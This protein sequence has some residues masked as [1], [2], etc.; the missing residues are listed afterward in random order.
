MQYTIDQRVK[1]DLAPELAD[2]YI[3]P[4]NVEM[5]VISPRLDRTVP[6][7]CRSEQAPS[8][9]G[10][11]ASGEKKDPQVDPDASTTGLPEDNTPPDAKAKTSEVNIPQEDKGTPVDPKAKTS[12]A[13][14]PPEEQNKTSDGLVDVPDLGD[15]D[16]ESPTPGEIR[17]S[18]AAVRARMRRVME[19]SK[20]TG[21]RK[22]SD[23][24]VK[25]WQTKKGKDKLGAI[26]Q[27]C[28]Y[29]TDW[30]FPDRVV[31]CVC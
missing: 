20:I 1:D 21:E 30:L 16:A 13:N 3:D 14:I 18:E 24:I 27:S 28:G 7:P 29:C 5:R 22:V 12:E 25:Q 31:F 15:Q 19:P 2:T 8:C 23:A 11:Q 26:F 17:L 6:T 10:V 4:K 9:F